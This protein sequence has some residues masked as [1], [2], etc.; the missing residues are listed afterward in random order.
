[1]RSDRQGK[2]Y[3]AQYSL[4]KRMKQTISLVANMRSSNA[5]DTQKNASMKHSRIKG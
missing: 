3:R 1:M 4:P 2:I 5:F